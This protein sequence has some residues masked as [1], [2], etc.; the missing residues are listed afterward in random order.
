M[1]IH[2]LNLNMCPADLLAAFIPRRRC[3]KHHVTQDG[4][5]E[6]TMRDQNFS[7]VAAALCR[8]T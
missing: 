1:F 4:N 6:D 3:R 8:I 2:A 7:H 5:A